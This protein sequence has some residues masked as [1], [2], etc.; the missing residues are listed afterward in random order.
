MVWNP[1]HHHLL[2]TLRRLSIVIQRCPNV[3]AFA[4]LSSIISNFR[5]S[6]SVFFN[7]FL[8]FW[9]IDASHSHYS[10]RSTTTHSASSCGII[11]S[12]YWMVQLG[13]G[14]KGSNTSFGWQEIVISG[15]RG[16]I[17]RH[18]RHSTS[19]GLLGLRSKVVLAA[20]REGKRKLIMLVRNGM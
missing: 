17:H 2:Y 4:C 5:F 10:S 15:L 20:A 8:S 9:P 14:L 16:M 11:A 13:R 18:T 19:A 12:Y 1:E 6:L 7:P 3:R